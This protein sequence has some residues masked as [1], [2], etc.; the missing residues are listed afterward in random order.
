MAGIKRSREEFSAISGTSP[1]PAETGD[2]H[3]S[4][5][6]P[7]NR[8]NGDTHARKKLKV[9][10]TTPQEGQ[11]LVPPL[12]IPKSVAETLA[13]QK[14]TAQQKRPIASAI[15]T[16]ADE[17]TS[18]ASS[19]DGDNNRNTQVA[20]Q[21]PLEAPLPVVERVPTPRVPF[22]L[23]A[24]VLAA[25]MANNPYAPTDSIARQHYLQEVGQLQLHPT[26]TP[27]NTPQSRVS[28]QIRDVIYERLFLGFT[29]GECI[30]TYNAHGGNANSGAAIS[31][32][33]LPEM[34]K[35]F[36][37]EGVVLPWSA[38][39][40]SDKKRLKDLK[41]GPKN[42]PAPHATKVAVPGAVK[43]PKTSATTRAKINPTTPTVSKPAEK[44]PNPVTAARADPEDLQMSDENE[45]VAQDR[46]RVDSP[47]EMGIERDENEAE[48][49]PQVAFEGQHGFYVPHLLV[50]AGINTFAVGGDG[51]EAIV[52]MVLGG[53]KYKIHSNALSKHCGLVRNGLEEG[54]LYAD[55]ALNLEGLPNPVIVRAFINAISPTPMPGLPTHDFEFDET[56]TCELYEAQSP[57]NLAK[58]ED[59]ASNVTIRKIIWNLDSCIQ[60]YDFAKTLDCT[61]VKDMVIDRISEILSEDEDNTGDEQIDLRLHELCAWSVA[62]DAK[63][64][65]AIADHHMARLWPEDGEKP[66]DMEWPEEL[67]EEQIKAIYELYEPCY[68]ELAKDWMAETHDML[69][70]M[71]A[72][73]RKRSAARNKK[74]AEEHRKVYPRSTHNRR[75][76]ILQGEFMQWSLRQEEMIA[77]I[78]C[79]GYAHA[80][81]IPYGPAREAD[82]K[83]RKLE[84]KLRKLEF[85]Y[86]RGVRYYLGRFVLHDGTQ[87]ITYGRD[88]NTWPYS[89]GNWTSEVF[90]EQVKPSRPVTS[91]W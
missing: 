84:P 69:P 27:Q 25:D 40:D 7:P 91:S 83:L 32:V 90:N 80:M 86:N 33:T 60:M 88:K 75:L 87:D 45:S 28:Q 34:P 51:N 66:E 37:E 89:S 4:Q 31:K 20:Q 12:A 49:G 14:N 15:A 85:D 5:Q 36:A 57:L 30:P 6:I 67:T 46:N 8:E 9:K 65:R 22:T 71:Y 38:R 59:E 3:Y 23:L 61:I 11:G 41:L 62:E 82:K 48:T 64:L 18:D 68:K 70:S 47:H 58:L 17:D 78:W 73:L 26:L 76:Y 19:V 54:C 79:E 44:V 55:P 74:E 16:N 35:W 77:T 50:R 81:T 42:F 21:V 52:E 2:A 1:V 24:P 63:I 56:C 39:K 53:E 10:D 29:N 43:A 72:D 13:E